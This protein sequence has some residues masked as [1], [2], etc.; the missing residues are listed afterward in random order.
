[1]FDVTVDFPRMKI[2]VK[3]RDEQVVEIRYFPLSFESISPRSPL[4]ER[5]ARQL[6]NYREDPNTRFDLPLLI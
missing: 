6:E 1:M 3:T 2:A 4:A 5:A